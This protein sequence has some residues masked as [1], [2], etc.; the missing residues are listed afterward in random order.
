[1]E[2]KLLLKS[3]IISIRYHFCGHKDAA[4]QVKIARLKVSKEELNT[5][6]TLIS[7]LEAVRSKYLIEKVDFQSATLEKYSKFGELDDW[8]SKFYVVARIAL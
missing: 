8:M 7:E 6:N 5:A 1:M 2:Q 4:L 3:F